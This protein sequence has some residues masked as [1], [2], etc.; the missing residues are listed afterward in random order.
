MYWLALAFLSALLLGF[1][2]V[3][4]K[5]A[6]AGNAV[7][8]ILL[9]KTLLCTAFS[10]IASISFLYAPAENLL[11]P[12]HQ[13]AYILVFLKSALV[14]TSWISGYFAM[15]HLPLTVVGPVNSTRPV[16][17][18]IGAVLIYGET[19][20]LW[21]WAGVAL[22][23]VA[24]FMLKRSSKGEI[25]ASSFR[26]P[27]LRTSSFNLLI[28]AAIAGAASGLFDKYLLSPTGAGLDPYFVQTWFNASQALL[29]AII[30]LLLWWPRRKSDPFYWRWSI[31]GISVFLTAADMAYFLA[32]TQP[33]AMISIVSMVRRSS[34]VV[35]FCFG[36]FVLH[37]RNLRAKAFDLLLLIASL[38][39]LA[40]GS[41]E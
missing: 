36:A 17:V 26:L 13:S 1:Y 5:Q 4:K 12:A 40:L 14:L 24:F 10:A 28:F 11:P 27:L 30:S 9:L 15:K 37:E 33:D 23:V 39:F 2:D 25:S 20:N 31:V 7:V 6:L 22:A 19:L 29:M 41:R 21:Q 32:L 16:L 34:V 8:P 3:C 35:S 38:I 18:L